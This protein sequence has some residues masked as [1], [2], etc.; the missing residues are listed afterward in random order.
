M[1]VWSTWVCSFRM[2]FGWSAHYWV[3]PAKRGSIGRDCAILQEKF[4]PKG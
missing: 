1:Q 4:V 2:G 3:L